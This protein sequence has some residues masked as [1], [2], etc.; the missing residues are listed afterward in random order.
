M[1]KTTI[2]SFAAGK[3]RRTTMNLKLFNTDDNNGSYGGEEENEAVWVVLW[4]DWF[5]LVAQREDEGT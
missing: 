1:F 2:R 4:V 3:R 5:G